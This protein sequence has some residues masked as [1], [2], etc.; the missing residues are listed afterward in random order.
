MEHAAQ[1]RRYRAPQEDGQTLVDPPESSLPEVVHRNRGEMSAVR[2]DIQGRELTELLAAARLGLIERA[3]AYTRQYRDVPGS[4]APADAPIVLSGHQPQLFHPG[5][6]YK[7]FVLSRLAQQIGGIGVHLLI[8]SDLC[9]SVSIRVPVGTAEHPH[10]EN[11]EYDRPDIEMPYEERLVRD[12]ATFASFPARV[13]VALQGLVEE[14]LVESLWP[15]AHNPDG[16]PCQLGL[17]LARARHTL[18]QA[19]GN[20]TLEL[21]QSSVCCLPEFAWFVAHVLAH[22]PRFWA[23]HN[24]SLADYRQAHRLRTRA[25]PV[26]D[27]AEDDG[28]LE[29]PFWLWTSADPRRRPL[30]AQQRGEELFITDRQHETFSLSLAADREAGQAVDQLLDLAARGLKLR[31][32]ALAT[33]LFARLLLGDLFIHGIGGAKYDQVTDQIARRFFGFPLPQ[34]ATVT[35][36]LRLPIRH[37]R[38]DDAEQMRIRQQLRDIRYH[39][40]R[41]IEQNGVATDKLPDATRIIARK[42]RWISTPKRADNARRRHKAIG[43]ANQELQ[44]CVAAE[45]GQLEAR[46]AYVEKRSRIDAILEARDYSLCL[47]PRDRLRRLLLDAGPQSS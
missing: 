10:L 40:E 24:D 13:R 8:D 21:P 20:L 41:Y 5:V 11:T 12:E 7:N 34:F 31:T 4:L 32:R 14:P 26:P 23:A 45:R 17:R 33:T 18:E 19:W 16:Q 27:L 36:T 38:V 46:L 6:W 39:P 28:W 2:C 22:L 43:E 3:V 29:S 1:Y 30:Y 37:A 42:R 44:S 47:F 25:H 35:A 15:L 9:R